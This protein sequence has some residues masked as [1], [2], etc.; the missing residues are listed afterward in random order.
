MG[1]SF[2]S[3]PQIRNIGNPKKRGSPGTTNSSVS[4]IASKNCKQSINIKRKKAKKRHNHNTDLDT[5]RHQALE[6]DLSNMPG[7]EIFDETKK[8]KRVSKKQNSIGKRKNQQK[9]WNSTKF[10]NQKIPKRA[11][12]RLIPQ[13]KTLPSEY[14][15]SNLSVLS[16]SMF[17]K[18][19]TESVYQ[20]SPMLQ[21]KGETKF[22][23]PFEFK[24]Y[25]Q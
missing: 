16:S 11:I 8:R 25:V 22:G 20:I 24:K 2:S 5:R 14:S 6:I 18:M 1:C 7:V 23:M 10:S 17:S 4:P 21:L 3:T 9:R 19:D 12:D 15:M 13:K